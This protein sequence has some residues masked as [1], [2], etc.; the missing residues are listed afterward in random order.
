MPSHP[1]SV[2]YVRAQHVW[3]LRGTHFYHGQ[4]LCACMR[5]G[6]F[7]QRK[8]TTQ[9]RGDVFT[10]QA[11]SLFSLSL[12]R[13]IDRIQPKKKRA[14]PI[15]LSTYVLQQADTTHAIASE[16]Q[17]GALFTRARRNDHPASSNL[18]EQT[19]ADNT[20]ILQLQYNT[21]PI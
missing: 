3:C 9:G 8:H 19:Q 7:A 4:T 1:L 2:V 14:R 6:G 21:S 10:K 13:A 16:L 12:S 11:L 17:R 20:T 5:F 15:D 18:F